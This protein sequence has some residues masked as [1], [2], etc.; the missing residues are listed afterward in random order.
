[1][2]KHL[3]LLTCSEDAGPINQR[4][5]KVPPTLTGPRSLESHGNVDESFC[6]VDDTRE[7]EH[8]EKTRSLLARAWTGSC[9]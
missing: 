4:L 2:R 7:R 9:G 6:L 5:L 1:M 8:G 3:S